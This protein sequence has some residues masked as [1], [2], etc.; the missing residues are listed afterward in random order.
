MVTTNSELAEPGGRFG[1]DGPVRHASDFTPVRADKS[2]YIL[3]QSLIEI[4]PT[5]TISQRK[6]PAAEI[7]FLG[8]GGSFLI[9]TATRPSNLGVSFECDSESGNRKS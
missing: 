4:D 8:R 5:S 2:A 1:P 6:K 9:T 7:H 3:P